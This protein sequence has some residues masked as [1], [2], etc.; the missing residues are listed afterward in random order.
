MKRSI[1]L[2]SAAF[3]G[4]TGSLV[5]EL[6]AEDVTFAPPVRL[7]VPDCKELEGPEVVDVDGDGIRDLLSGVYAGY[8]LVRQNTGTNDAPQY[9]KPV[10]LQSAGQDIK[11]EHW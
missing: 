11:L 10:R 3:T 9:G 7:E 8:L 6:V 2:V 5:S 4:L 1:A